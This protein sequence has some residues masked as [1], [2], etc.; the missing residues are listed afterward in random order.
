[1]G[2]IQ[3][4]P[5]LPDAWKGGAVSGICAKGNFEV[6]MVWENNQLKK[7]GSFQC[8]RKLCDKYADKTLSFKTVKG[9]SYRVEYDVTKGLI[10]Q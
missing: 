2:F 7:R 10:R 5:A 8:G 1:M 3:L 6:D 4:L 9:R